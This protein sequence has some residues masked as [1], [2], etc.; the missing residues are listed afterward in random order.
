MIYFVAIFTI[1]ETSRRIGLGITVV[2]A[3][4]AYCFWVWYLSIVKEYV[5]QIWLY[6]WGF[7]LINVMGGAIAGAANVWYISFIFSGIIIIAFSVMFGLKRNK[8]STIF[9]IIFFTFYFFTS[10]FQIA[11]VIPGP[12]TPNFVGSI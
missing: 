12:F 11:I 2:L 4:I 1:D 3:C 10:S 9:I 5:D 6:V 7:C 8:I